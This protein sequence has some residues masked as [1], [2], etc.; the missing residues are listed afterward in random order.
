M[1][2]I[3]NLTKEFYQRTSEITVVKNLTLEVKKGQVFG[4]IGPNGAGKTT[5]VKMIGG[6]LFPTSGSILIKNFP[7]GS[8]ESKKIIGFMSENPQFYNHLKA[9][10]VLEFVGEL[11]GY[12]KDK[13]QSLIDKLL[14][15]VGLI[16]QKELMVKK[17]SKGMNQRLAFAVAMINDPELLILDEPLDGLDPLGRLDFKRIILENK[18]KGKTIFFSSHILSDVEEICDEV[19]IMNEG[20]IL[21]QGSPKQLL[22]KSKESLEELF[23]RTVRNA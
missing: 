14:T 7:A 8:I 22:S 20:K 16:K 13:I 2:R 10:E 23:V 6:L 12:E 21:Q 17:F 11:F 19:A 5:T 9:R 1:L 18:K 3:Q 4:L 15:Q